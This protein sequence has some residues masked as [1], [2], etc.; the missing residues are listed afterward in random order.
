MEGRFVFLLNFHWELWFKLYLLPGRAMM[1]VESLSYPLKKEASP[2]PGTSWNGWPS[3]PCLSTTR[4]RCCLIGLIASYPFVLLLILLPIDTDEKILTCIFQLLWKT[5]C[6][7]EFH[8]PY[9]WKKE[10]AW[11]LPRTFSAATWYTSQFTVTDSWMHPTFA[12]CALNHSS[13]FLM[14]FHRKGKGTDSILFGKA[15]F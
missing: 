11:N 4:R 12:C 6:K 15:D 1:G 8:P 5:A 2:W 14:A 3:R 9:I 13:L 7:N 10:I